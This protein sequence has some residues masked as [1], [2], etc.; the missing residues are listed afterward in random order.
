[1]NDPERPP[2]PPIT[3]EQI[4]VRLHQIDQQHW[5]EIAKFKDPLFYPLS[6]PVP[7]QRPLQFT[8]C[9]QS[10]ASVLFKVEAD[11]YEQF[12]KD[13]RYPAW[14]SRLVSRIV[15][16]VLDAVEKV[17]Y[18]NPKMASLWS[19]GVT[20]QALEAA[21]REFLEGIKSQYEWRDTGPHTQ[22]SQAS[23]PP[24]IVEQIT[25]TP[26]PQRMS[27]TIH[28]PSAARKMEVYMNAKGLD[29]TEFSIQAGTTDKTI[30]KFRQTGKI[31]RTILA[32]I[33]AAMG[34]SR[35]ELLK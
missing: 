25:Q 7:P 17:E 34:I 30:R 23:N 12:R 5:P 11:E 2:L 13:G 6:V 32:G 8:L 33:A 29:Q 4:D 21:L 9:L 15:A 19:H 31:K 28:A 26:A 14:L 10:Y 20:R 24:A 1:M 16:R 18:G 22:V 27:A 3:C 35:E